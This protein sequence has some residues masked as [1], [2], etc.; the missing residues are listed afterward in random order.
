[1]TNNIRNRTA[2][3][4][5]LSIG[6]ILASFAY[7][8]YQNKIPLSSVTTFV[9]TTPVV[10]TIK[11][12]GQYVDGTYVGA[13]ADAY[14]GIIQVKVTVS[15][16][17]LTD[18]QFLQHPNDRSTSVRI[19]NYAMPILR[20]EAIRAQSANVDIVSGATDSSQAFV[21][22]MSSALAQAKNS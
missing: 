22:S 19:N 20:Q 11:P 2:K 5:T 7:A 17:A 13:Q 15:N 6:L 12:T 1:M 9:N 10:V 3:K 18:V 21:Q 4:I 14:Y 8:F 16:G